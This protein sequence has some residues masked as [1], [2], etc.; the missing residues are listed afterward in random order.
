M[1][2][3]SIAD[4]LL[5]H[6]DY[7]ESQEANLYR[8]RA[9]RQAATTVLGLT[10]PVAEILAGQG[11][12]GLEELPGIGAHLSF[13]ID[14][15][16]R[17]GELQ[18]LS[19]DFGHI[20]PERLLTSL[21]GIGPGLARR[22]HDRLG[23]TT[24]EEMERA[25]YDGRLTQVEIGS[26]RL[27]GIRDALAGRLS[28]SRLPEPIHGE[29][30]VA[31]LLAIDQEY[32]R[33]AQQNELPTISPSR[34]NPDNEPWLPLLAVRRNGWNYRARYSNS[35]LAHRLGRT[36]DWVVVAFDDGMVSGQ[37][38]VVTESRRGEL[39]GQRVVRGRESECRKHYQKVV[40]G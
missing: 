27:R 26:K 2:N 36:E 33:G 6:A 12:K 8:V 4:K 40:S 20:D 24:L 13:A 28:R 34:F 30:G 31:D 39:L 21:P 18:T 35:A 5:E 3:R 9:Y 22:I 16:V 23:I 1:D 17:T 25:A 29:P 37:R 7:L 10:V 14:G 11:R 32:R 38:T 15:L 19:P